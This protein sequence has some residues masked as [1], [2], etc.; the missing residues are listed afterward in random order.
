MS[1]GATGPTP[2]VPSTPGSARAR[3]RIR[4]SL[5]EVKA[6]LARL[7]AWFAQRRQADAKLQKA[8]TQLEALEATLLAAL[9]RVSAAL[10]ALAKRDPPPTVAE[11]YEACRIEDVRLA[12]TLRVWEWYRRKFDQA[13]D[14]ELGPALRAG[15]EVLWSC[16]QVAF[17]GLGRP[18]P[19]ASVLYF[20]P[21]YSPNALPRDLRPGELQQDIDAAFLA[22]CLAA[23]PVPATALPPI[24]AR[25]PWW[26]A[27]LA[28][29]AGHHVQHDLPRDG[30]SP[31]ESFGAQLRTAAAEAAA[32]R[33]ELKP[34]SWFRRGQEVF[35]DLYSVLCCG[36]AAAQVL[37]EFLWAGLGRMA[38]AEDERYPAALVR[39]QLMASAAQRLRLAGSTADVLGPDLAGQIAEVTGAGADAES[40]VRTTAADLNF[41]PQAVERAFD[42]QPSAAVRLPELVGWQNDATG[43]TT[44][45]W[46]TGEGGLAPRVPRWH[47]MFQDRLVPPAPCE[48]DSARHVLAAAVLAWRDLES[49][50]DDTLRAER[51]AWLAEKLTETLFAAREPGTRAA[52]ADLDTGGL[53]TCLF[54]TANEP[55]LRAGTGPRPA[56]DGG[57]G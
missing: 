8:T 41:A 53:A 19:T 7:D 20:E 14:P 31:V 33:P 54:D 11:A 34:Q 36:P 1:Q 21:L 52:P 56:S 4:S 27:L 12:W 5:G 6:G 40:G 37:A 29:E 15:D 50:D 24:C 17:D 9:R 16:Y 51:S 55:V 48:L 30:A 13:D 49:L 10:E 44:K 42:W 23:M 18:R 3:R 46:H 28:H 2:G 47:R 22:K 35:A 38:A 57:S 43:W 26:L 25:Q 45:A 39:L 32:S